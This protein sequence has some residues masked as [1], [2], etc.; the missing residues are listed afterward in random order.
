MAKIEGPVGQPKIGCVEL[1]FEYV[2]PF[3]KRK[4][5]LGNLKSKACNPHWTQLMGQNMSSQLTI[6]R[7]TSALYWMPVFE[8]WSDRR[9][10]RSIKI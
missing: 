6:F 7:Q 9:K 8:K 5:N 2:V 3:L 4:V 1:E 10:V